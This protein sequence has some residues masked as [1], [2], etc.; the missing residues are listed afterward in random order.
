MARRKRKIVT[1]NK[2]LYEKLSMLN[3]SSEVILK[4]VKPVQIKKILG[5]VNKKDIILDMEKV[6]KYILIKKKNPINFNV[7]FSGRPK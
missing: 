1:N 6:G 2:E 7:Y 3:F 5:N 4:G